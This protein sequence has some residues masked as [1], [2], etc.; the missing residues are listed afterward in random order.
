MFFDSYDQQLA[1][2]K[3]F[4]NHLEESETPL[5]DVIAFW[6]KAPLVNKHLN[7]NSSEHWPGPWQIIKDGKYTEL[8]ISL[9][10]GHTLK[11]TQRFS[12]CKI[13]IKSYLDNSNKAVYNTCTIDNKIL[14]YPYGE[15]VEEKDLPVE[16][17]LQSVVPIADFK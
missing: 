13:E 17:S 7:I 12:N 15:I 16:F 1:T 11:L 14:N 5:E 6:N 9:M 4:R 3:N 2:W 8:T 10:I